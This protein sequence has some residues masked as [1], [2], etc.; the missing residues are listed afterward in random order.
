MKGINKLRS[1]LPDYQGK[2]ILLFIMS[3]VV[4]LIISTV[5]QIFIDSFPRLFR[6]AEILQILAPFSPILG[7]LIVISIG[8]T[9][10]YN[11]WR[12]RIKYLARFGEKAYQT[13][14]KLIVIAIPLLF[15]A[16]IH[17]FFPTDLLIPYGND[18]NISLFLGS[19]ISELVPGF[20]YYFLYFRLVLAIFLVGLGLFVIN[21]TLKYFG[22]DYMAL[23]Y[24]YY[25]EESKL[26]NHEIYSVLRHPTYHC[27]LLISLGGIFFRFSI[28]SIIYFLFLLIGLNI[29]IKYVE[30]KE[31][32]QRFGEDYEKYKETVPAF[33]VKLKDLKKYFL[34][35]L[36]F[37]NLN[38]RD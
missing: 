25:P 11:F 32:I 18:D 35:L 36:K 1:K 6:S 29:H 9:I 37:R 23:V 15:S 13:S 19:P 26:R 10:V 7:S 34:I 22:I 3:A 2:R 31:L 27:L 21:R 28:Y 12:N 30:E 16:V 24:L 8:F 20:P 4:V 17:S 5:F 38:K 14:F 33:F